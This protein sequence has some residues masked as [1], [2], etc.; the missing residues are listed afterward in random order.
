MFSNWSPCFLQC[1]ANARRIGVLAGMAIAVAIAADSRAMD[2]LD[3]GDPLDEEQ[4]EAI[5]SQT[6]VVIAQGLE[7]GDLEAQ[8]EW[9]PGSGAIVARHGNT[10]YVLTALHVV[11]TRDVVYGVRTS[12]GEVHIVDDVSTKSN[13]YPFGEEEGAWGEQIE[14]FD[15]AIV[16]FQ[17]DLDYAV[18]AIGKSD[19]LASGDPLYVSGWPNPED[20][21]ARRVRKTEA[22]DLTKLFSQPSEDGGYSLLYDNTTQRGMSGGPV[23]NQFG[24]LVGIHGRGRARE[25]IYCLD[26]NLSSDNSCGMQTLH[27]VKQAEIEG[28]RLAF[29]SP[30]VDRATIEAGLEELEKADTIDNIYEDFTFDL[31]SL[32]RDAPSG[33]C[34]SMLLG[35]DC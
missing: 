10:Y 26:P 17:S 3:T 35:D 13:I 1:R 34:G 21:S 22:G 8:Q 19:R 29:E 12:D 24:E 16:Q 14:G 4:I 30:P 25:E 32:L 15:L 28:L 11:R 18:S 9:N 31:R 27:F 6:T 5:A 7:K 20:D 23:L 33:G 2:A